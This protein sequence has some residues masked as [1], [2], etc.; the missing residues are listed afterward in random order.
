MIIEI[1]VSN[2]RSINEEQTLSFVAD[3]ATRH[4]D[5]LIKRPG[6]RLLKAIGLFGAN[7]SGKS[8]IVKAIGAMSAFVRD[9]ATKMNDGDP[10][11]A[12]EPYRLAPKTRNA[13][14][15]F[16]I[17]FITDSIVYNYGFAA[18]SERVHEE[19]LTAKR[20]KSETKLFDI[21]REPHGNS[22]LGLWKATGFDFSI[23]QLL[24]QRCRD[25]ALF[26]STAAREN[27][28]ELLPVYR[29]FSTGIWAIDMTY[30]ASSLIMM[31][32]NDCMRNPE[33]NT[34]VEDLL[35][36]ADTNVN[37]IRSEYERLDNPT[38]VTLPG[39]T[40]SRQAPRLNIKYSQIGAEGE[41]VEFDLKRDAS[42][43]T[44]HLY[45]LTGMLLKTLQ[46]GDF[47]AIDELD[48]SMHPL[49][50]RRLLEMF[51]S[52]EA[53]PNGAQLLFTTHDSVL[54]DQQ[55]FRRDQIWLAEKCNGASTFFSLADI[56][57]PI[58]NTEAFLGNY[59]AG[60]Y[61]GTP[62]LG[63]AFDMVETGSKE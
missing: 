12:A 48:A 24:T 17:T 13:P 8:N 62:H 43:G 39:G 46:K 16:E 50:T 10:I 18:D 44:Q 20:E 37:R 34:Q 23:T 35:R 33:L 38:T 45:G 29:F 32:A 61:G 58:R 2:Y 3:R 41:S 47:L 25:N 1:K 52:P 40:I 51:Q 54:L 56:Q 5:N 9:S 7:A 31:T 26:L 4:P 30:L 19:W 28:E 22:K 57:P 49:L 6:H 27:V 60:R 42:T 21:S 11:L 15:R 53:N 59:L 14:S 55:L 63:P 36:D